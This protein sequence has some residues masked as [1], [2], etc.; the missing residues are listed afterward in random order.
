M[1]KLLLL[2]VVFV[3]PYLFA[4]DVKDKSLTIG[5]SEA[6]PGVIQVLTKEQK[7]K[8]ALPGQL[9]YWKGGAT[10]WDYISGIQA[11]QERGDKPV[12]FTFEFV[13]AGL[14]YKGHS[15]FLPYKDGGKIIEYK[16]SFPCELKV[17]DAS[18][19]LLK[20]FTLDDGTK[21]YVAIFHPDFLGTATYG[22]EVPITK[23][24]AIKD[25]DLTK[26]I[27]KK[28]NDIL[29]RAEYN[30]YHGYVETAEKIIV[31]AYAQVKLGKPLLMTIEK[32]QQSSFPE[33]NSAIE[34]LTNDVLTIYTGEYSD[35]LKN[36]LLS[37]AEFFVSQYNEKSP[38]SLKKIC[39]F[40]ATLAYVF[41][42]E[43]DKAYEQYK[44]A[45]DQFG[46]FS[47]DPDKLKKMYDGFVFVELL[48]SAK[49]VS[50]FAYTE[51]KTIGYR[52]KE[53]RNEQRQEGIAKQEALLANNVNDV[54][55]FVVDKEGK[56]HEGIINFQCVTVKQSGIVDLDF[57]KYFYLKKEDGSA[58]IY[59]TGNVIS[60]S[61]DDGSVKRFF[62]P[63]KEK[64]STGMKILKVA[65]TG[66]GG[67]TFFVEKV[68]EFA[69]FG[70]YYNAQFDDYLI[71]SAYDEEAFSLVTLLG[72]GKDAAA[73]I[74]DCQEVTS[75]INNKEIKSTKEGAILFVNTLAGCNK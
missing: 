69:Q 13:S 15:D 43:S 32:K 40:N 44:V 25:D 67:G 75:K 26:L 28:E 23:G 62:E 38:K 59:K 8:F 14:Q 6:L 65:M 73:F 42:G 45:Y 74:K 61:T 36:S 30:A 18:G 3:C 34:K 51:P 5:E 70:V 52:E 31:G 27:E 41:G 60:F 20:T 35:Q 64:E 46:L 4:E 24:F 66:S 57:G 53:V 54:H 47:G 12:D 11:K 9:S 2:L 16:Y 71:K 7:I 63:I 56:V 33:L 37:T 10:G 49:D 58:K 21:D 17:K 68:Y 1:K 39:S 29:S 55:G 19:N 72:K 48:R 22:V 50:T